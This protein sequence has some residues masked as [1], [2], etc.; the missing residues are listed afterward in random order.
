MYSRPMPRWPRRVSSGPLTSIRVSRRFSIVVLDLYQFALGHAASF[1]VFHGLNEPDS[2]SR[3]LHQVQGF[4][5][6]VELVLAYHHDRT[7]VLPGD[8]QRGVAVTDLIHIVGEV[9][10]EIRV[11]DVS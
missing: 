7:R 9:L 3:R 2:V 5:H 1:H 10:P 11:V 6:A 4:G 8:D